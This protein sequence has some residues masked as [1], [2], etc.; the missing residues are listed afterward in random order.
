MARYAGEYGG[1]SEALG[2]SSWAAPPDASG[3]SGRWVLAIVVF[4]MALY[5]AF[6]LVAAFQ[7]STAP[8]E[9]PGAMDGPPK[10]RRK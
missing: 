5:A 2:L 4:L 8:D 9:P 6:Q 1:V 7:R 10:V 3:G